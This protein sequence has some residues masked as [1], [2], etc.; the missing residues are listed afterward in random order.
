[1]RRRFRL[2][3]VER[4]REREVDQ[5]ARRVGAA[6]T[7]LREAAAGR[8]RLRREL[9]TTGVPPVATPDQVQLAGRRRDGL[10]DRIAAAGRELERLEAELEQA[11]TEWTRARARLRAVESLHERHRQAVR[12]EDARTE[13]REL[14]DLAVGRSAAHAGATPIGAAHTGAAHAGAGGAG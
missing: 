12:D 4:L 6:S 9:L 1:V 14:D 3:T 13:Q 7:A 2:A 8:D 10:R 5:A 11:R